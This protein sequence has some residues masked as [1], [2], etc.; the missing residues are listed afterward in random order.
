MQVHVLPLLNYF[1]YFYTDLCI[2]YLY[3]YIYIYTYIGENKNL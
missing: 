1:H 2:L 3:I